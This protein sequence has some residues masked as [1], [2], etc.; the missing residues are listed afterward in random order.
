[1]TEN[2]SFDD[3]KE[4]FKNNKLFKFSSIAISAILIGV[5]V[6]L[7]YRQFIWKPDNEKSKDAYYI[8]MNYILK[9]QNKNPNDTTVAPIDPIKKLQ[10]AVKKYDGKIG[11]EISKYLLATQYMR[12]GKYKQAIP[13]LEDI[14]VVD[15]YMSA[16]IVGLQGDCKSEL[17]KYTEAIELYEIAAEI[18]EN[19]FTSPMYL[20]KAALNAEKLKKNAEANAYYEEIAFHYPNSFVAKQKNMQK[21]KARSENKKI[22]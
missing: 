17:K 16:M 2:F 5:I 3:F 18:N 7:G 19:N 21:Y 9:E 6:F 22:N 20:F 4:K 11:G 1:M 15:T 8:P 12:N 14:V 13:L 10:G